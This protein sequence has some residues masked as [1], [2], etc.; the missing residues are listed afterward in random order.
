MAKI[1]NGYMGGF[2]GTMG[3]T[4][5]YVWNGKWC[6][7]SKPGIV[8]NPRTDKQMAHRAMFKQEVQLASRLR[9]PVLT[10]LS[11]DGRESA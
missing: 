7:R 4:V 6:L 5:G 3:P 10:G 9:R 1:G 8:H 2:S 11:A